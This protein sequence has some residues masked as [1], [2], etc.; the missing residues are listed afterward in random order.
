MSIQAI[1]EEITKLSREEQAELIH[2]LVDL[3]TGGD[4][5]PLEAWRAFYQHQ[6]EKQVEESL[7]TLSKKILNEI[8][9][10]LYLNSENIKL[11]ETGFTLNVDKREGSTRTVFSYF[12]FNKS[13][14]VIETLYSGRKSKNAKYLVKKSHVVNAFKITGEA[15]YTPEVRD[16]IKDAY[17]VIQ[18]GEYDL[19]TKPDK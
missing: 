5:Q 4:P 6:K 13:S 12:K 15:D 10:D 1:K 9:A 17:R 7:L 19:M 11:V 16:F 14:F 18:S 2:F 8:K 3:L